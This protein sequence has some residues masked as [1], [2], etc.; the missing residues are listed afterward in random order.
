MSIVAHATEG[1]IQTEQLCTAGAAATR[2]G[3]LYAFVWCAVATGLV[4]FDWKAWRSF[5]A[6]AS[7][8]TASVLGREQS[9]MMRAKSSYALSATYTGKPL[10]FREDQ[11]LL[12]KSIRSPQ[13]NLHRAQGPQKGVLGLKRGSGAG[14]TEFFNSPERFSIV[15]KKK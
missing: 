3:L 1:S 5:C 11:S 6:H 10:S 9:V 2:M 15:P 8:R 7:D 13:M 4:V 14:A 12:K